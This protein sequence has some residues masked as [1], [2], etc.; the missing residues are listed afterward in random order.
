MGFFVA[1]SF[2]TILPLRGKV[3]PQALGRSIAYFPAVGL[4]LGLILV[5]LDRL[6][7]KLL[8]RVAVDALLLIAL[9][10]LTGALH[11]DGFI[12]S[13]DALFSAESPEARLDRLKDPR[14]GAFGAVGAFCLLLLKYAA[15]SSLAPSVK[16]WALLIALALGRFGIVYA[17]FFYP[18]RE[19][20]GMGR[21]F[22]EHSG[23]FEFLM[24]AA[25][26]F[27][28]SFIAFKR[29]GLFVMVVGWLVAEA[30]ARFALKK[31]PGLTGDIYG[32]I[33]EAVEAFVLLLL[34]SLGG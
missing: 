11:L 25:T 6:F 18:Y 5:G 34:A 4:L 10:V 31:L 2:L 15:L 22:K 29:V 16:L 32:A 30:L 33:D 12:D 3:D 24:A 8:P 26:T 27:I 28:V 19:G 17:I 21:A 23:A 1:I 13:C 20:P 7:I 14:V 9:V